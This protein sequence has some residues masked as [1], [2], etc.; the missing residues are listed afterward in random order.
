MKEG[1]DTEPN[2]TLPTDED[3]ELPLSAIVT[4]YLLLSINI[5]CGFILQQINKKS[6]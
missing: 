3:L 6:L 5:Y 1:L 2:R 4:L